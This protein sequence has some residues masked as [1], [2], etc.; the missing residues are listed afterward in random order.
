MAELA[1]SQEL[2]CSDGGPSAS[3]FLHLA[4]LQLLKAD[5]C[6]AAAS[7][8]EA[9]FH[10]DQVL[11]H[12]P[13]LQ[14]CVD[15]VRNI[16]FVFKQHYFLDKQCLHLCRH[17]LSGNQIYKF[18]GYDLK[19]HILFTRIQMYGPGMVTVTIYEGSSMRPKRATSGASNSSR[20]HPTRTLSYS[21]WDPS[22]LRRRR[23]DTETGITV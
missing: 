13:Q 14:H 2:L 16:T 8:K 3:Y 18:L 4:Q 15:W 19:L 22:T 17:C 12:Y 20:S 9:L 21:T 6:S 23:S 7:L 1:L 10:L 11:P 5:Y